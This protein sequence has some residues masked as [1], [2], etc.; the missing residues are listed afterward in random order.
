MQ[1][2]KKYMTAVFFLPSAEM[3]ILL[4]KEIFYHVH[5]LY[6]RVQIWL[7]RGIVSE[8]FNETFKNLPSYVMNENVIYARFWE[9]LNC[10]LH[11]LKLWVQ[12]WNFLA[13]GHST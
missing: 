11:T 3:E 9:F 7:L 2:V 1:M 6:Q 5:Y 4:K 13:K 8:L 10:P 12:F